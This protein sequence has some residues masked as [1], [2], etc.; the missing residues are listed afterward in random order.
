MSLGW[1]SVFIF[2]W[3]MEWP[4]LG[5]G[6]VDIIAGRCDVSISR[7]CLIYYSGS[8]FDTINDSL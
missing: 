4:G 5:S 2:T 6:Q 8:H 3:D 7:S 1:K